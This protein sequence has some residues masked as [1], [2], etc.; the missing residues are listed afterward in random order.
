MPE[1]ENKH[2]KNYS[3]IRRASILM[4]ALG[5]DLS[6]AIMQQL[7]PDEIERLTAEIVMVNRLDQGTREQIIEDCRKELETAGMIGGTE[8]ARKLLEQVFGEAKATEVLGKLSSDGGN[9][10]RW[11]RTAPARQLAQCLSNERSQIAAL[12]IG[13]LPPEQAA[14][15]ISALPEKMQGEVALRLTVMRPTDP[16]TIKNVADILLQRLAMTENAIF[17]EVGGN[18]SVVSILNNVDRSTEKKILEYLTEMNETV[19]NQ[20]KES[21]FVFEDILSLDDRSIQIILRDVPQEDLRLALKGAG[22]EVKDVFFR[23]MSSR[24]VE[25]LKEDLEAS[26]PIKLR[27]VE[28]AQLRIASIARQLDEAGEISLRESDEEM[29]V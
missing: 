21:M 6:S 22:D 2:M 16:E 24:A 29:M 9:A 26:G 18:K 4:V 15:V 20:I 10:L 25:T 5:A 13:H 17:T 23:N 14:Q 19:A 11:L 3:G 12:V 28:A 7:T 8:Y 1:A 27:D